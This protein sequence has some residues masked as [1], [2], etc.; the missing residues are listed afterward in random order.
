METYIQAFGMGEILDALSRYEFFGNTVDVYVVALGVFIVALIVF[1]AIQHVIL[2]RLDAFSKKTKTDLDDTLVAIVQSVR[3]SFYFFFATYIAL[4][5]LA[6]PEIAMQILTG[7]LIVWVAVQ[8]VLALQKLID[9]G[10]KRHARKEE[11]E[12]A[13][14]AYKYLAN[15]FKWLLWVFAILIVLSN[16][17]INVTSVLAG[18]G[19]AG[20]AIGFALQNILGDLFSS[21]AI[22]FDKPFE[23]GDFIIVGEHMGTVEQVGIKTT[24][25]RALQGEEIVMSNAE[26]TSARVQNFRKLEERRITFRFGVLYETPIERVERIP[27]MVRSVTG[28]LKGVRLDRVHFHAFGDSALE[29]EAVYYALSR[30]Y[31]DYMDMQQE[32]NLGIMRVFEKEGIEFAYPTQTL[33]V[34]K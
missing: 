31:N 23:V 25:I 21:F 30:E 33:Y 3:P 15:I 1:A 17:G 12:N 26:L 20:V 16:F 11:N 32:I 4:R 24:R 14:A 13:S 28:E 18:L 10:V 29:F 8:A 19:I 34:K 9:Y 5:S 27:D 7:T 2:A 22:Y 6:L